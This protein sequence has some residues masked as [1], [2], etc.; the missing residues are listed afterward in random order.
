MAARIMITTADELKDR[1]EARRHQLMAK[2]SEL[3]ADTR[4]EAGEARDKIKQGLSDL[5]DTLR[6][7]WDNVSDAVRTKL[8]SWLD[9]T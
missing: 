6:D 3:K 8:N 7:G 4:H 9:R 2:L 5:E 1:V